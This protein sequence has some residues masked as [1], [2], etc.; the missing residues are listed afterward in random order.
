MTNINDKNTKRITNRSNLLLL[1]T[2]LA[3]FLLSTFYYLLSTPIYAPSIALKRVQR[4]LHYVYLL[5]PWLHR[6]IIFHGVSD[7]WR[8][9]KGNEESDN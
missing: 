2:S 6:L 1:T 7:S 5:I 3:Y 8:K 4:L 9:H